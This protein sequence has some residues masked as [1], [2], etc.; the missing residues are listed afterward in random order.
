[1]RTV[2]TEGDIPL[3]GELRVILGSIITPSTRDAARERGVR[4]LRV[5]GRTGFR[6]C[7]AG[8]DRRAGRR[9]WR[10]PH[11]GDPVRLAAKGRIKSEAY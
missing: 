3:A 8:K 9:P 10:L 11:E 2:I 1:M 6:H 4:I 7:A 5:A